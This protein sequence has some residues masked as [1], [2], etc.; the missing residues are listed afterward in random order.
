[1]KLFGFNISK[2]ENID[3]P[4]TT[5]RPRRIKDETSGIT[6]LYRTRQDVGKWRKALDYAESRTTPNRTEYYRLLKDIV[7]DGHLSATIEQRKNAILCRD[8]KVMVNG[9]YSE[10]KTKE[11]KKDWFI[12]I[13]NAILDSQYYGFTLLDLG[14]YNDGF[15]DI[16]TVER[17]Y[18]KP[19]LNLVTY[20][21]SENVGIQID[22]PRYKKWSL[23]FCSDVYNLGI[24]CKAAPYVL[25]KK[26]AIGFWS[27]HTEKFGQPF[28]I[29]KTDVTDEVLLSNMEY[30]LKNMG[31]SFWA[32]MGQDDSI[33]LVTG[34]Q[35]GNYEI[36]DKLIERCNS[37][38][39]KLVL[40]QTGTTDEKSFV[41]SA[42]VHKNVL[43][44]IVE[45][46]DKWVTTQVN[47]KVFEVL[48]MHGLGFENCTF[49]FDYGE[50]LSL[51]D[52]AEQDAKMMPYVKFSKEY[53][54]E[55][56]Q[57]ELDDDSMEDEEPKKQLSTSLENITNKYSQVCGV[58]GG[59]HEYENKIFFTKEELEDVVLSVWDG[60]YTVATLPLWLYEKTANYI[61]ENFVKG[62]G[63]PSVGDFEVSK[64]YQYLKSFKENI[65]IFSGA[66]TYQQIKNLKALSEL[67][68]VN[69]ANY[70]EFKKEAM[71]YL[72]TYN[73]NYLRTE[74][75]TSR[76]V[77]RS[78]SQWKR[79]NEKKNILPLLKY[80]T[81]GDL[82]VRPTHETLDNIIRPIDD[83]FW[84]TYY[85]PNG[86]NCRC[87]AQQMAEGEVSNMD[88]FIKPNDVPEE[89]QT[90]FATSG[91]VFSKE[92]DYFNIAQQD[93]N[94][95]LI[96]FNLPLPS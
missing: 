51:K 93:K 4:G 87:I 46:D 14:A 29:G 80:Q 63:F 61:Y 15:N 72:D 82:R 3:K 47:K 26:N 74:Y 37:E 94:L 7:L 27:E 38:L 40:G 5:G 33:E 60:I 28:R 73:K 1:M 32:V 36:Y 6:D 85:P 24:L 69:A 78:V 41:G 48:N 89:F 50:S 56:Y 25:W 11:L 30:N 88:D 86:W 10:D 16:V 84:K 55:T 58:C 31:S 8:F 35:S 70:E 34:N 43:S 71:K 52:K 83:S 23:Y 49:E 53:L 21:S 68:G 42:Q 79:I 2:V 81:V 13:L 44:E 18:V 22:D 17:Q 90:N 76:S 39:S 19:E 62:I 20:T 95:A 92:H 91:Y 77:G 65:F 64:D 66:K 59:V 96:N 45:A 57:I 54:E 12:K 9:E 67:V 75:N